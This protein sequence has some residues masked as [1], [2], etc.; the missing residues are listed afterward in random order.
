MRIE[1]NVREYSLIINICV[2]FFFYVFSFICVLGVLVI[3]DSCVCLHACMFCVVH[4]VLS[5]RWL[6]NRARKIWTPI[7]NSKPPKIKHWRLEADVKY[8]FHYIF[9]FFIYIYVFVC[10][11]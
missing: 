4:C 3:Y 7:P 5:I 1:A 8:F 6:S 11:F 10:M 9:T 2:C